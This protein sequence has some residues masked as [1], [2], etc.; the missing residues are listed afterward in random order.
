MQHKQRTQQT[1]MICVDVFCFIHAYI[2]TY[3]IIITD[4][5]DVGK[6]RMYRTDKTKKIKI[7]SSV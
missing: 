7:I 1:A 2:C 6:F 4:S 5:A 3:I